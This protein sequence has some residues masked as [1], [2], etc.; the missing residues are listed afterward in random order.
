MS[1]LCFRLLL[2]SFLSTAET[3]QNMSEEDQEMYKIMGFVNFDS[4]KVSNTLAL[5]TIS[6]NKMDGNVITNP[7]CLNVQHLSSRTV[8]WFQNLSEYANEVKKKCLFKFGKLNVCSLQVNPSNLL[9][10]FVITPV[11]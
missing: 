7:I 4:T 6:S 3:L 2:V 11:A 8:L 10:S 9:L 5:G 1:D